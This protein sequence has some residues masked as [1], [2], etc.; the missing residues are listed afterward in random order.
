MLNF[1]PRFFLNL[2]SSDTLRL[3][4]FE[5]GHPLQRM[6]TGRL[7]KNHETTVWSV[8][9]LNDFTVVSGDSRGKVS[10]WKSKNGTLIDSYQSHKAD[11]LTVACNEDQNI[12]YASGVDPSIVHFQSMI[13]GENRVKWMKSIQR[14]VNSHDVHALTVLPSEMANR[15]ISIGVDANLFVDNPRKKSFLTAY[16]PVSWGN[17]AILA[18]EARLLCMKYDQTI[19]VW[20]LGQSQPPNSESL[21]DGFDAEL[22][23]KPV[24][25]LKITQEPVKVLEIKCADTETIQNMTVS[26]DGKFLAYCT[27]NRFKVLRIDVD[28][29]QIQKV[30]IHCEK[31]PHLL[32]FGSSQNKLITANN[33]GQINV[34][35]LNDESASLLHE[36]NSQS[37]ISHLEADQSDL[38]IVADYSNNITVY[39]L[40]QSKIQCKLPKYEDSPISCMA[41]HPKSKTLVVVYSNHHFVE[42]CTK[43]GKHTKLTNTI[44]D[45]FDL[46]P[47]EWR[48]KNKVTRGILFP[49]AHLAGILSKKS[50]TILFYDDEFIAILDRNVLTNQTPLPTLSKQAKKGSENTNKRADFDNLK[51]NGGVMRLAK[52]YEHL[53][54]MGILPPENKED[55]TCPLVAVE[56][57]PQSLES[58]LP[59]A[60]RKKKFGAM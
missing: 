42:C 58:Q 7:E 32:T 49:Q 36:F 8:L 6:S 43:T 35:S 21:Q 30:A 9:M 16:P 45:N 10:F 11:V 41:L 33:Y 39:D 40:N 26:V 1:Y 14:Y 51:K 15:I 46:V 5:S 12:V 47:H 59:P 28:E 27:K 4:D 57:K 37:G 2:G 55:L 60:L 44:Q 53:I 20:R 50:D 25:I 52:R 19:E 22:H 3:W 54:F 17:N 34:F 38:L 23:R 29:P 48:F 56:V 31:V 24:E 18:P 13:K